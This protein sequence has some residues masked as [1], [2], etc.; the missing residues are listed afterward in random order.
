MKPN[1]S[2]L[3]KDQNSAAPR[4][5][6]TLPAGCFSGKD[7]DADSLFAYAVICGRRMIYTAYEKG[8]GCAQ[9]P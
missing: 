4:S 9:V 3:L 7:A 1:D 6:R 5:F 2:L 8:T